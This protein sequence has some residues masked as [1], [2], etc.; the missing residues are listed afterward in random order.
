MDLGASLAVS[1][2]D[3]SGWKPVVVVVAS[4]FLLLSAFSFDVFVFWLQ[5]VQAPKSIWL[6]G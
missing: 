3:A 2:L 1:F 4:C 5:V 6:A